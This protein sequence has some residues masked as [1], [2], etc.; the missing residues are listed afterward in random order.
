MVG[1]ESVRSN[2]KLMRLLHKCK[3]HAQKAII[4]GAPNEVVNCLCEVALNI[5][6]GNVP[7]D[8]KQKTSLSKYKS[9]LRS[10]AKKSTS[11]KKKRQILQR[12]GFLG[13]LLGPLL[14]TILKPLAKSILS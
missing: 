5:L 7:L 9:G 2:A 11:Q 10:L 4:G 12:G 1:S 13:A 3:P 14:G 8:N 6:K